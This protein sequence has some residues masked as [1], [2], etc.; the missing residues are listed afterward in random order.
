MMIR[1]MA[2]NWDEREMPIDWGTTKMTMNTSAIAESLSK[3]RKIENWSSSS[4]AAA[5]LQVKDQRKG[6]RTNTNTQAN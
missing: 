1:R 4:S 5:K 2:S 3:K 6:T